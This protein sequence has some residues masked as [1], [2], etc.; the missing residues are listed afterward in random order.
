[1]NLVNYCGNIDTLTHYF[2]SLLKHE[3][4]GEKLPK[5]FISEEKFNQNCWL[6]TL[7]SLIL[8]TWL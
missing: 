4:R 6:H 7:R 1:M 3:Y 5:N 8:L 2:F